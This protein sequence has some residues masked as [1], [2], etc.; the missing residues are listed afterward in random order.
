MQIEEEHIIIA[1]GLQQV[2]SAFISLKFLIKENKNSKLINPYLIFVVPGL[3]QKNFIPNKYILELIKK[4]GFRKILICK[5]PSKIL[6][7]SKKIKLKNNKK[8][9]IWVP[10]IEHRTFLRKFASRFYFINTKR[11][12]IYGDGWGVIG[13]DI[14]F[15]SR[16]I[17]AIIKHWIKYIDSKFSMPI[18]ESSISKAVLNIPIVDTYKTLFNIPIFGGGKKYKVYKNVVVPDHDYLKNK[19]IQIREKMDIYI[20]SIPKIREE[21]KY[22]SK[23][24][25]IST[26]WTGSGIIDQKNEL[27]MIF[28]HLFL[29]SKKYDVIYFKP[30]PSSHFKFT[31]KI[32]KNI[33]SKLFNK[34]RIIRDNQFIP[35]E[36]F[37]DIEMFDIFC[38]SSI[39]IFTLKYLFD[40]NTKSLIY[41][42]DENTINA[43]GNNHKKITNTVK[44][45]ES[46]TKLL[47]DNSHK[48][49]SKIIKDLFLKNLK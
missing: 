43:L 15:N 27:N 14:F 11:I 40:I 5:E 22:Y 30:H 8:L 25:Y 46:L 10:F 19:I 4:I 45:F 36:L 2:I 12:I 1:Q 47:N 35:I 44:I 42:L 48:E 26:N 23:A 13:T 38:I 29:L 6:K 28:N 33:N 20:E 3:Y 18:N 31:K 34:V 49:K 41:E 32:I 16:N 24:I 9:Y 37:Q 39:S 7:L 17:I 21:E